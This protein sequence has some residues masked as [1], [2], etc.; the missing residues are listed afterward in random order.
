MRRGVEYGAAVADHRQALL[1]HQSINLRQC[2][3]RPALPVRSAI[4]RAKASCSSRL[5]G[6]RVM[7]ALKISVL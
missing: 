1:H 4:W 6:A 7:P 5:R 3:T 2:R